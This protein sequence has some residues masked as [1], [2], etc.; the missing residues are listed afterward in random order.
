[1]RAGDK[2]EDC[3]SLIIFLFIFLFCYIGIIFVCIYPVRDSVGAIQNPMTGNFL[4]LF[5]YIWSWLNY[6]VY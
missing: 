5:N 6:Y 1:M 3:D 2:L 4:L